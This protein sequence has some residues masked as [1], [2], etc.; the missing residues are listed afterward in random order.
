MLIILHA[1]YTSKHPELGTVEFQ[2]K[3]FPEEGSLPIYIGTSNKIP[4]DE[5]YTARDLERMMDN[6]Y[7]WD[8]TTIELEDEPEQ[9][10]EEELLQELFELL[11]LLSSI[12]QLEQPTKP[13][14]RLNA[15]NCPSCF[16]QLGK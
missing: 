5:E 13:Q 4:L 10:T 12:N 7:T 3:A 6:G 15:C 8:V 16:A 14:L 1:A 9:L 11:A 2:L